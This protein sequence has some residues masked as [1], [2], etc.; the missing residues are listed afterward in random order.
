MHYNTI[1]LELIREQPELYEQ[2][3]STKRLLPSMDA[4]AVDLRTSHR[5][6]IETFTRKWPS[7]DRRQIEAEALE[8]AIEEL[9]NRLSSVSPMSAAGPRL[10][11][12]A[13]SVHGSVMPIA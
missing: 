8:M 11:R 6:M 7:R 2:L 4:Y 5:A 13:T 3:R 10:Q 1:T 12:E 9:R